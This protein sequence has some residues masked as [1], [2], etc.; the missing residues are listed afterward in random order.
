MSN[1]KSF[2]RDLRALWATLGVICL[3]GAG[4]AYGV[5]RYRLL[6]LEQAAA[7]EARKLAVEVI[8]P[9]LEPADASAPVR[10]TRYESMLST[11][12]ERVLVGP[13][14]GVRIWSA[15]GTIV[16]A[17]DAELVG[18]RVP[19]MRDDVLALTA[20]PVHGFV[21]G[22]RFRTLVLLRV[23]RSPTSLAA[24]LVRP[25]DPLV[26]RAKDPWYPW[27]GRAIRVAIAFA[28][29]YVLTWVA[30]FAY[31]VV[32]RRVDSRRSRK[33]RKAEESGTRNS[34]RSDEVLPAYM[35]PGFR[36]E[37]ETRRRVEQ[38][39]SSSQAERDELARRLQQAELQV[40]Q[41]KA[42]SSVTES[43]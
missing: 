2:G 35:L 16:F 21:T 20:E 1:P 19:A 26:A 36:D 40:E 15:E 28:V 14:V 22:E 13:I 33:R 32:Q 27:V 4:I 25:H 5:T 30:F 39:L 18:D 17:D 29:L 6:E 24:E 37:V 31:D 7:R 42:S 8:Q 10:G 12:E 11:I 34:R 3:L 38:E 43:G 41:S 9:T 23:D